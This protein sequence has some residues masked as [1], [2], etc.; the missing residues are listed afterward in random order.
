MNG[1]LLACVQYPWSITY[2]GRWFLCPLPAPPSPSTKPGHIRFR[3]FLLTARFPLSLSLCFP[4]FNRT[5]S[6]PIQK[7]PRHPLYV[8]CSCLLPTPKIS[9]DSSNHHPIAPISHVHSGSL[10]R[11]QPLV[12]PLDRE[13][14]HH[15][16]IYLSIYLHSSIVLYRAVSIF[17]FRWRKKKR[18]LE[19]RRE[20][21]AFQG[22]I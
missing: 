21:A 6:D 22:L 8:E 4:S 19:T 5:L 17:Q 14:P 18:G 10:L 9:R 1:S 15:V 13:Q 11:W 3:S 20:S 12:E 7:S 16:S 2:A